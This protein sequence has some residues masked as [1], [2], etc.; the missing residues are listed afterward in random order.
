MGQGSQGVRPPESMKHSPLFQ[1][2]QDKCFLPPK[3]AMMKISASFPPW[4]MDAPEGIH[5][6][7]CEM[8]YLEIQG[9]MILHNLI[10]LSYSTVY[11]L[12]QEIFVS[13]VSWS[14]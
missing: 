1:N 10:N 7:Y 9:H 2:F 4:D 12:E 5:S 11:M 6:S 14:R 8:R 3:V 13:I